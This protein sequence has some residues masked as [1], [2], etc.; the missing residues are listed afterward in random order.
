MG[1]NNRP[2]HGWLRLNLKTLMLLVFLVVAVGGFL[3]AAVPM[4]TD[5]GG[6][7]P[8]MTYERM[9]VQTAYVA[10]LDSPDRQF[11]I[12]DAPADL[13]EILGQLTYDGEILVSVKPLRQDT[14]VGDEVVVACRRP[15]TNRPPLGSCRGFPSTLSA[16][17]TGASSC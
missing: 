9:Y 14:L 6:N 13:H 2:S 16:M 8:V 5:C 3:S 11:D 12:N 10:A 1:V 4:P 15:Y 17:R 7:N